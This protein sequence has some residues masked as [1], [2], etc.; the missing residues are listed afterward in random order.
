MHANVHAN[1]PLSNP[2]RFP[3]FKNV[4]RAQTSE[5]KHFLTFL[6]FF[7]IKSTQLLS[8]FQGTMFY[9]ITVKGFVF[10]F[11]TYL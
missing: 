3:Y 7:I 6:D 8:F 9:K 4:H 2:A 5:E 10:N 1:A 11:Q